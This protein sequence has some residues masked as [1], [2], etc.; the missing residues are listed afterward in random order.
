MGVDGDLDVAISQSI[1]DET[2]R[3]LRD[4]FRASPS[5][6]SEAARI[7]DAAATMV[8]PT[9]TPRA[10]KNDPNDDHIVACAVAAEADAIIT[11]DKHL[12]SMGEYEG[13][14]MMRVGE[15]LGRSR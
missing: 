1:I 9:V 7:M 14:K 12:L 11:G 15:S 6:L 3:V 2:L 4:K 10:V 13:I 8:Y 5:E